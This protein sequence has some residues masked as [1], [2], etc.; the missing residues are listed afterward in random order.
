[1][2]G[3]ASHKVGNVLHDLIGGSVFQQV[4]HGA[5]GKAADDAFVISEDGHHHGRRAG[6]VVCHPADELA[7]IAIGQPQVHQVDL[8]GVGLRHGHGLCHGLR[9]EGQLQARIG[10]DGRLQGL[11]HMGFILQHRNGNG[12]CGPGGAGGARGEEAMCVRG[13]VWP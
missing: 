7:P 9:A 2:G 3:A 12:P 11:A 5:C 4:A 6:L 13:A 10:I 1:M 8:R